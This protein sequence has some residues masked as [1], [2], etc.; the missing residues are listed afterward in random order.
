MSCIMWGTLHFNFLMICGKLGFEQAEIKRHL[1]D[2]TGTII[3]PQYSLEKD[4]GSKPTWS[5]RLVL[6]KTVSKATGLLSFAIF[7]P[8][9]RVVLDRVPFG[10]GEKKKPSASV[11]S[12]SLIRGWLYSMVLWQEALRFLLFIYLKGISREQR[13]CMLS[14]WM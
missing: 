5:L 6:S 9:N 12:N 2:W 4:K 7:V 14:H 13:V 10:K 11:C 1:C 8:R 3:F